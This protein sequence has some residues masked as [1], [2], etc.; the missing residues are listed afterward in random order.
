MELDDFLKVKKVRCF[1]NSD[2][3]L[4]ENKDYQ[5]FGVTDQSVMIFDDDGYEIWAR[6]GRFEPVIES[7]ENPLQNIELTPEFEAVEPNNEQVWR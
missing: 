1:D 2:M 5:L 7:A 6:M 4:T 3:A